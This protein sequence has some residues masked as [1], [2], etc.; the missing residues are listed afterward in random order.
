LTY[1]EPVTGQGASVKPFC[2]AAASQALPG[3]RIDLFEGVLD[4]AVVVQ[5]VLLELSAQNVSF[6]RA[7]N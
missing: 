2:C 6:P 3:L 1:A 5:E 7:M 4:D